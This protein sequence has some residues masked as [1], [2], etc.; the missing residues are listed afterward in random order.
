M[1]LL[2]F[3]ERTHYVGSQQYQQ[4][5]GLCEVQPAC[6]TDASLYGFA[7]GTEQVAKDAVAIEHRGCQA[8]A[9]LATSELDQ[10]TEPTAAYALPNRPARLSRTDPSWSRSS[11]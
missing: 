3:P 11:A 1:A 5:T 7:L 8:A 10:A 2:H 9:K 4:P 6:L